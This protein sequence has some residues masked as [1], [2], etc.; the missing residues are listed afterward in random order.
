ML[1]N[2]IDIL[3]DLFNSIKDIPLMFAQVSI[4]FVYEK[5]D[6]SNAKLILLDFDRLSFGNDKLTNIRTNS[7]N[8][9]IDDLKSI[10]NEY[11]HFYLIRHGERIDYLYLDWIFKNKHQC[12]P[13]LS[14]NGNDQS[15]E[16]AKHIVNQNINFTCIISSPFQRAIDMATIIKLY[17]NLPLIIDYKY[18]FDNI[19]LESYDDILNRTK[20]SLYNSLKY[21][22]NP[23]IISHKSTIN[24]LLDNFN[25][26]NNNKIL[27][28]ASISY[29]IYNNIDNNIKLL[30]YNAI[31]HLKTYIESP[32]TNPHYQYYNK[33]INN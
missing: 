30:Y 15:I 11:H 33:L 18:L 32:I 21:C 16:T 5:Q 1:P 27:D 13:N 20:Y 19:K 3:S 24:I 14:N 31:D 10:I 22:K 8:T 7:I 29:G 4:V 28:Y 17:T 25:L 9:I 12:D 6:Y 2:F 26:L 23:I